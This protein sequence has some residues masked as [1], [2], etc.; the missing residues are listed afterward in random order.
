M[1]CECS[2]SRGAHLCKEGEAPGKCVAGDCQCKQFKIK[3]DIPLPGA[4]VNYDDDVPF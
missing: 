1:K 4:G 3:Y 2:H